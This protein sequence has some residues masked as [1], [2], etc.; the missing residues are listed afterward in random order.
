LQ[1][2]EEYVKIGVSERV[3]NMKLN[4]AQLR[5]IATGAVR[6][7]EE[8][9]GIRFYRFTKEQEELYERTCNYFYK[10]T[11]TTAG[12]KLLFK[13]NS[14]KLF[15]DI[16]V[17]WGARGVPYHYFSI[18]IFADGKTVGYLDN[19][20]DMMPLPQDYTDAHCPFGE[21]SKSFDLGSGTKLLCIHLPWSVKNLIKEISIDDGAFIEPVKPQKKLLAFGDSIT[22]G[23]DALRPSNRYISKL[24]EM[25][26]AEEYNKAIGG[27]AFFPE[28]A[29]LKDSFE[30]DYITVAYGTNDWNGTDEKTL[31]KNSKAFY[32]NISKIYPHSKIFAITPIWRKDMHEERECGA[33]EDVEK[34]IKEAVKGIKNIVVISGF[35]FVPKEEKYYADLRLHPNDE[36]FSHYY[37]NLYNEIKKY[38]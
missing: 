21:F 29:E 11:L 4:C 36:G 13:T 19:F 6:V 18:D 2:L 38:I 1:I 33:F 27:E 26:G 8:D 37:K 9:G 12:I 28:L 34:H 32:E 16:L 25:L 30:P 14:E 17:E 22:H 15:L 3:I 24:A 10:K 7:E 35:N 31:K 5:E 23:Y 20:S